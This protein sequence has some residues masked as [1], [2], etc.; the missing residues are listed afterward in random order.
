MALSASFGVEDNVLHTPKF[1]ETSFDFSSM[2]STKYLHSSLDDGSDSLDIPQCVIGSTT[3]TTAASSTSHQKAPEVDP[4]ESCSSMDESSV[5]ENPENIPVR[6]PN[7]NLRQRSIKNRIETEIR[8]KVAKKTPK[9]KQRPAPLSKY[10][11][12]TANARERSRMQEINEAFET[13]RKV[14]PQFPS[15]AGADNAKLTKITTL[16][17]AVNYIAALSQILKQADADAAT[18]NDRVLDG[19]M[20]Q[21]SVIDAIDSSDLLGAGLGSVEGLLDDSFDLILESD[22]DSLPLSDDINV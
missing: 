1:V 10:R 20:T 16:R 7:Y 12:R 3:T 5:L 13:L 15:K 21:H 8:R 19:M 4:I 17:L 9:P 14:V 11:R 22:G 2:F 6:L 18:P